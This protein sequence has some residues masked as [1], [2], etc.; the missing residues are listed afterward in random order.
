MVWISFAYKFLGIGSEILEYLVGIRSIDITLVH[1][2]ESNAILLVDSIFDLLVWVGFLVVKLIARESDD[3]KTTSCVFIVHL[4][5]SEIVFLCKRSVGGNVDDNSYFF[6]LHVATQRSLNEID[7]CN[8]YRPQ[9]FYN[10]S[11]VV[12]IFTLFP[13]GSK[14]YTGLRVAQKY[15]HN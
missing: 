15:P 3:L 10:T 6:V 11:N 12:G 1:E 8:L 7:I 5:Q 13:G 14:A 4:N 9:L 2:W